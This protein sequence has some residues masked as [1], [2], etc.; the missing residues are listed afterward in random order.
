MSKKSMLAKSTLCPQCSNPAKKNGSFI[1]KRSRAKIQRFYCEPCS[2]A[3]SKQ[4]TNITS[5]QHRP[6]L[7]EKIFHMICN[8]MGVRRI[9][10]ALNTTPK[11]VQKK[12]QFLAF[13]CDKFH[14]MH[15]TN[16]KVKP[17]FQFD[18]MWAVESD[19]ANTL[20]IP[21]VVER[22]SY[23]IV[24][25]RSAHT[26]S[27]TRTHSTRGYNNLKRQAKIAVRDT[28]ILKTLDKVS[29]MKPHGRIVMDTDGKTQYPDFLD[30]VF[31]SR[32]VHNR[33]N[34]GIKSEAIKLFPINNT[35]A[36]MRA[37]ISKVK[38]EGW[39]QTQ[40]NTWLN[41]HL[42]IYTVYY[43]YFRTKKYT[44]SGV[45]LSII[46]ASGKP[47]KVFENKTPAMNL[48]I[49]DEPLSFK[50]LMENYMPKSIPTPKRA[51][52]PLVG[53]SPPLKKSA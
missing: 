15:F 31:G 47:Q 18:E 53:Y 42:V 22:D 32:L 6:D 21:I 11:T 1:R 25:A 14:N 3:F 10:Q 30:V 28:V 16:W 2:L 52:I 38:R 26:F 41:A 33:Y 4:T 46:N 45:G 9:A 35:M 19:R 49:F 20:T 17:K 36:C 43:N 29:T 7:N 39:Y 40:D 8:G 12:I 44:V 37:E 13:L 5:K 51:S 24:S 23:F 27:I 48:G 34:A 50:F